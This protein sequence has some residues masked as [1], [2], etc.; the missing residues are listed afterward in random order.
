M[1]ALSST[2]TSPKS[3]E[4]TENL[5]VSVIIPMYNEE[6]NI[7]DL[8][9]RLE[10]ILAQ[11]DLNYEIVCVDDGSKDNTLGYLVAHQQRNS[12]IKV[13]S[14]SRNFGK[15]IAMTAGIDYARGQAVILMDAD[16]QD[17]PELIIELV[18][19][20][21]E[22][23]EVVYAVRRSRQGESWLK[24]L[25]AH[26]FY[27]VLDRLSST[28]I[29]HNAGDFRLLDKNVVATLRQ[30]PERSRFMKGLISWVGFRQI[31]VHF[32]RPPRLHGKT[33]WNYWKLWNFALDGITAF[34]SVPLKI[35]TY[36]GLLISSLALC[37]AAF[38]VIRT[39]VLGVDVPGY[40]SLMVVM[41]TLGGVQLLTLGIMGEYLGRVYEEVKNRPIYL[42]RDTYG[43]AKQ[44]PPISKEF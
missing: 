35:W 3:L 22:G 17:P 42:V 14:L 1:T 39:L 36:L 8:L 13:I 28:P 2:Q 32:D 44:I 25:T 29:P 37:Y 26:L 31:A 21:C 18:T 9:K 34:S 33:K 15:D 27:Q 24:R 23:Y 12:S 10:I 20:W 38:L 7:D 40:A 6:S 30:L 16:L 43:V 11:L 19:R 41:L 4:W 5:D